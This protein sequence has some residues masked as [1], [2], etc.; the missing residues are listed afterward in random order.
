MFVTKQEKLSVAPVLISWYL[1]S[2]NSTNIKKWLYDSGESNSFFLLEKHL[3]WI[4]RSMAF[5]Q[6][7]RAIAS[8]FEC[9]DSGLDTGLPLLIVG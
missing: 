8:S 5:I 3:Q 6:Q 4:G 9:I 2:L 1:S 7:S